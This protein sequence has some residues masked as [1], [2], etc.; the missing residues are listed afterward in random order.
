MFGKTL[1]AFALATCRP[2]TAPPPQEAPAPVAP[3]PTPAAVALAAPV[4][5]PPATGSVVVALE[6]TGEWSECSGAGG[7]HAS[8]AIGGLAMKRRSYVHAGGHASYARFGTEQVGAGQ[9]PASGWFVGEV[10]LVAR[11]DED[12]DDNP[13][14]TGSGWCLD[15]MPRFEGEV[16]RLWSARDEADARAQARAG[17]PAT[18]PMYSAR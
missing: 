10:V 5:H 2:V 12:H 6:L 13:D 16:A 14:S 8:L 18:A 1:L 15:G 4:A 11:V 3:P 7:Y 9:R 17:V